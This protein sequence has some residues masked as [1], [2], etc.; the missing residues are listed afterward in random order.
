MNNQ[1]GIFF[2]SLQG[3]AGDECITTTAALRQENE[4]EVDRIDSKNL[5]VQRVDAHSCFRSVSKRAL[6]HRDKST[7]WES[8][9]LS[10]VLNFSR[11]TNFVVLPLGIAPCT[12]LGQQV[13]TAK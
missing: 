6:S 5:E 1:R 12:E 10:S 2:K 11:E 7:P 8:E 13:L 4:V 3:Y 9:L